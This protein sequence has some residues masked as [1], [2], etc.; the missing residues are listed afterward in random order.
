MEKHT[1]RILVNFTNY[2]YYEA[3]K[4]ILTKTQTTSENHQYIVECRPPNEKFIPDI[5]WVDFYCLDRELLSRY[6][7][8]KVL[9]IDTGLELEVIASILFS[10]NIAGLLSCDTDIQLL[11][12]AL[13]VVSSGKFWLENKHVKAF[14][15]KT[16]FSPGFK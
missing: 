16:G 5:I 6:P 7:D 1:I 15:H 13:R 14:L 4:S 3:I 8:A 2:I 12:K 10:H 9:L 11:K